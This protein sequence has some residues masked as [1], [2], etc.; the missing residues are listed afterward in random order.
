MEL[1]IYVKILKVSAS[2]K[3][4]FIK[5]SVKIVKL[6][7]FCIFTTFKNNNY[8]FVEIF[9]KFCYFTQKNHLN[10]NNTSYY[11]YQQKNEKNH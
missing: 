7:T 1:K 4:I 5:I 11:S 9:K 6:V 10:S 2:K 8:R 3:V